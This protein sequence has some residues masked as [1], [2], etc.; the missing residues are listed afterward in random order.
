MS[1]QRPPTF[2]LPGS[3]HAAPR[4]IVGLPINHQ[5]GQFER[6]RACAPLDRCGPE[7]R[8]SSGLLQLPLPGPRSKASMR[9]ANIHARERDH[10]TR[11][12]IALRRL[13]H[14]MNARPELRSLSRLKQTRRGCL[15]P[16]PRFC[17]F[18]HSALLRGSPC[19]SCKKLAHRQLPLQNHTQTHPAL[20]FPLY[21]PITLSLSVHTTLS[22]PLYNIIKHHI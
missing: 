12:T 22:L 15:S 1:H 7:G 9:S 18:P 4:P 16:A 6:R 10:A 5:P 14:P 20:P 19:L 3:R 21:P 2:R 17:S 8:R 13:A 11:L